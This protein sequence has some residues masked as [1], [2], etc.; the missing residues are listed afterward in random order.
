MR[1][2]N[3]SIELER[4]LET[5]KV[6]SDIDRRILSTLNRDEVMSGSISQIRRIV[7][8]DI[9]GILLFDEAAAS[10]VFSY[11]WC[12]NVKIGDDIPLGQCSGYPTFKTGRTLV[13]KNLDEETVLS[14]MDDNPA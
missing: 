11:G 6:L 7:P 12:L 9:A 13:R 4:S 5:M 14:D 3:K 1:P 2:E 10:L 8:A